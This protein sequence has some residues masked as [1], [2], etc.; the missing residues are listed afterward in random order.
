MKYR[1]LYPEGCLKNINIAREWI[2]K[3]FY[4]NN[5]KHLH[6]GI[7]FLRFIRDKTDLVQI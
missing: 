1:P 6:S 3:F 4:W 5:H 2:G 7:N